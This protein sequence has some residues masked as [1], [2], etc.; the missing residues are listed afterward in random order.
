MR[1]TYKFRLY[2]NG[3]TEVGLY[4][5]LSTCR[6]L[7]NDALSDR[8]RQAEMYMLPVERDWINYY[9]QAEKLKAD[10]QTNPYLKEV[11]SQVLQDVL[12][13]LDK[14]FKNFFRRVKNGENPGYPR[15]KGRNRYDSFTYPQSG[16]FLEGDKLHLSKIGSAKIILHRPI[17]GM[18]KTCTIRRDVDQWY[19]C[20]SVEFPDVPKKQITSAVGVDVGLNSLITLSNGEK[21][22]PPKFLR[23]SEERLSREQRRLSRRKKGSNNWDRQRIKVAK[24]HRKIRNQRMDFNHKLSRKLVDNYGMIV[25]ENLNINNMVKNHYLAKSI[26]DAGWYQL[27]SFTSYKAEEAGGC[28]EF[29]SA[30]RTSQLCSSCNINVPKSLSVRTHRCPFCG[31]TINRDENASKNI[32]KRGIG[33]ELSEYTPVET[34]VGMSEKQEATQLVGW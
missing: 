9:D 26:S 24:V 33:Q 34:F 28:V 14:S 5:T 15:F 30:N 25:F 8:K 32:L 4:R 22:G 1:R 11:Y 17:E 10:K 29:V 16:F 23:K 27:Q 12:R 20:F 19:A 2:P 13:R 7:Y 3:N 6:H 21:I 31:L 18:I